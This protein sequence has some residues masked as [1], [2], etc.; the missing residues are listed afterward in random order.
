MTRVPVACWTRTPQ[1]WCYAGR[2]AVR[3]AVQELQ[4]RLSLTWGTSTI[5]LPLD[6]FVRVVEG[7]SVRIAPGTFAFSWRGIGLRE[8]CDAT[9]RVVRS[10]VPVELFVPVERCGVR[11]ERNVLWIVAGA[12]RLEIE[13][14][15]IR[16][17]LPD[18]FPSRV[19]A[20]GPTAAQVQRILDR[21]GEPDSRAAA[22]GSVGRSPD[23][24]TDRRG[25][26]W[27]PRTVC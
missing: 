22:L 7:R 2:I 19:P 1:G 23:R 12:E 20:D 4:R 10:P 14:D 6:E 27:T 13:L 25:D 3:L 5:R 9:G 11:V 24:Q 15:V 17:A 26:S 18:H 8:H 16:K 21:L